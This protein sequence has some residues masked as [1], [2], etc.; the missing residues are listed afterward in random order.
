MQGLEEGVGIIRPINELVLIPIIEGRDQ[1]KR[2]L[3][4][5]DIFLLRKNISTGGTKWY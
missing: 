2:T 5:I 3:N 4:W 1:C